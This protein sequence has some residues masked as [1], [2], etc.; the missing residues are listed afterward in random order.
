MEEQFKQISMWI[1]EI[2]E[3]N[4]EDG[5]IQCINLAKI[6]IGWIKKKKWIEKKHSAINEYYI[7]IINWD[8][9]NIFRLS[10]INQANSYTQSVWQK[11]K[12]L[13]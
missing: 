11:P 3:V 12:T 5:A 4:K 1:S 8:D 6:S 7:T 13:Y 9:Y 10:V 2:E